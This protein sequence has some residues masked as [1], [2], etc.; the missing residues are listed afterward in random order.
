M[1]V[2]FIDHTLHHVHYFLPIR[3]KSRT[4]KGQ[5]SLHLRAK[6]TWSY[7]KEKVGPRH[8]QGDKRL[9]S[10]AK[11]CSAQNPSELLVLH[12]H[13]KKPQKCLGKSRSADSHSVK[14]FH[15]KLSNSVRPGYPKSWHMLEKE[16]GTRAGHEAMARLG[17]QDASWHVSLTPLPQ[18]LLH[19][20]HSVLTSLLIVHLHNF[21]SP[22][23]SS[24]LSIF[25]YF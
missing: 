10:F 7:L 18:V 19:P 25:I 5:G 24:V 14:S 1:P 23:L 2:V 20:I 6:G 3:L 11:M 15:S 17:K 13:W 9:F 21:Q 16:T 4:S 22:P 12:N 8:C